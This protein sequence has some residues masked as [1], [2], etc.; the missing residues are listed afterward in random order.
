MRRIFEVRAPIN[1]AL[2]AVVGVVVLHRVP[3]PSDN[4]FL[5]AIDARK[6]RLFEGFA[7]LYATLWFSTP[8]IV[9]SVTTALLYVAFGKGCLLWSA[10]D[11][12]RRQ[13]ATGTVSRTRRTTSRDQTG[14]DFAAVVAHNPTPRPAYRRDDP[15][16]RGHRENVGVHVPVC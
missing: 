5:A 16:R 9:L 11:V 1:L 3:F 8:L 13:P 14:P 2:A 12:S 10:A 4:A 6:P 7:Y 15:R